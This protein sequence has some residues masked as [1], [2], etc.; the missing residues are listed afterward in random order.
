MFDLYKY[1]L[2]IH[3]LRIDEDTEHFRQSGIQPKYLQSYKAGI[4]CH[5]TQ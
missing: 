2:G 4:F 1:W 5:N 3:R